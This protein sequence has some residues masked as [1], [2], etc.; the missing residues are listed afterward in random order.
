M[1]Y[2]WV[3]RISEGGKLHIFIIVSIIIFFVLQM[4]GNDYIF[5]LLLKKWTLRMDHENCYRLNICPVIINHN[6]Y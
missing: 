2:Y 4:F 5:F 3:K 6:Y 1:I